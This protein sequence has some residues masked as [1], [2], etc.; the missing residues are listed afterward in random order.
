MSSQLAGRHV[1]V[2]GGAGGIGQVICLTLAAR[3]ATVCCLDRE[4]ARLEDFASGHEGINALVADI[5]DAD[6]LRQALAAYQEKHQPLD[7][8][9]NNAAFIYD[10]GTLAKTTPKQWQEE[11]EVNL[12]GVFN[13]THALLEDFCKL[14]SSAIVTISSVNALTSLGHPAYSAAKAG[15]LS[16]AKAVAMEYG[17]HNVRSNVVLPGTVATPAWQKRVDANPKI[18]EQLARW[19][20][21]GRVVRPEDVAKAVCFLLSDD[22]AAIS[23]ATLNVDCGLMAGNLPFAEELTQENLA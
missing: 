12:N 4:K 11:V 14:E 15:L 20:P 7:S 23:G 3:G 18:F 19:Y 13:I 6:G 21:L 5:G 9:V 17:R 22:A 2:T 8:L 16:F 1:L 10:I